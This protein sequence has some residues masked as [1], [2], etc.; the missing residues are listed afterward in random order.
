[1]SL[2]KERGLF[3]FNFTKVRWGHTRE[4]F[5]FVQLYLSCGAYTRDF[6]VQRKTKKDWRF[7]VKKITIKTE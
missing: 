2:F 4:G 3:L 5:I 6:K 1:M 7:K